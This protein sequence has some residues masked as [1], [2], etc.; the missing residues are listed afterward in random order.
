MS[1]L[2]NNFP[3]LAVALTASLLA[4][5]FGGTDGSVLLK[6]APWLI[7]L[8]L[9]TLIAF[10]Q[11]REGE[12]SYDA[13]ERVWKTFKRDPLCWAVLGLAVLL[14]IPFVNTGL[15]ANCDAALIAAG[16]SPKP[17]IP[18]LPFC[19]DRLSHLNVFLWF[20]LTLPMI[21][22]VR[23][24]LNHHGQ[25]LLIKLLVW[26]GVALS[27]LGFV[28]QA[29]GA[30]GPLWSEDSGVDQS[31]VGT[32][33]SSFGYPN[34]GGDYFVVLFGL[35]AALW[36][37]HFELMQKV[38]K[39]QA[40]NGSV[41]RKNKSFWHRNYFLIPAGVFFF[42]ALATLSRAA[43]LLAVVTATVYILH[44]LISLL[45]RK[46][47]AERV[48]IGT[49]CVAVLGLLVF[50]ATIFAPSELRREVNTLDTTGVLDRVTGR[51]YYH[52]RVATEVWLDHLLFG[53][54]GW[55]YPHH[56]IQKM[57]SDELK[58]IQMVGGINV[59][60]DY[61]QF[62]AEHGLVGFGLMVV[63]VILLLW[64]IF[65]DWRRL[66][67]QARFMKGKDAPA[68]PVQIF[69]LPAPVFFMLTTTVATFIHGF[70]DCPLRSPA[71]LS[72]FF[73]TLAA[74]PGFMHKKG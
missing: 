52:S 28:Q 50:F 1:F 58:S 30:P 66:A 71:V 67:K 18:V 5:L 2:F 45:K 26:N 20:A 32:F 16:A 39:D 3:V 53:C 68:K 17:P 34:M 33:F 46:R 62:L 72:L 12:S 41:S 51:G 4:W 57:T 56:C 6:V 21:L 55:G 44:S 60:N 35:A 31:S 64:P 13:R 70:G 54:G 37:D 59:H 25:R 29:A 63:I 73:I 40:V 15:C 47:R 24:G 8:L 19:V 48:R 10:P 36:R 74:L 23:H 43:I 11:R 22:I 69:A 27:V 65:V 9:E 61:L 7:V 14:A 42:S 49:V 38:L